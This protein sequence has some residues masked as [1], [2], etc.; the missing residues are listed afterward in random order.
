LAGLDF[1]V[2]A[3][4]TVLPLGA[5]FLTGFFDG[6][7]VVPWGGLVSWWNRD[8]LWARYGESAII[9]GLRM[10]VKRW[11]TNPAQA[12]KSKTPGERGDAGGSRQ[13]I[14]LKC[15]LRTRPQKG[16][17]RSVHQEKREL[18]QHHVMPKRKFA[19]I[20]RR[21]NLRPISPHPDG[22]KMKNAFLPVDAPQQPHLQ[23][24]TRH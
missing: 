8:P 11:S 19:K 9:S 12:P 10:R 2:S 7:S 3:A 22:S 1:A 17:D 24:V 6:T 23:C 13:R 18:T 16:A 20:P 5:D 14:R 21:M 4:L 15:G